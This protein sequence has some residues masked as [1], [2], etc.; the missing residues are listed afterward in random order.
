MNL[1]W[2]DESVS[3]PK[4][5]ALVP[6]VDSAKAPKAK[7]ATFSGTLPKIVE[8]P[9][10]EPFSFTPSGGV[11]I[12][13][14]RDVREKTTTIY[15]SAASDPSGAPALIPRTDIGKVAPPIAMSAGVAAAVGLD[16]GAGRIRVD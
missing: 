14:D 16:R 15:V 9:A 3:P 4:H 8:P 5:S 13:K 10:P 12:L 11:P 2:D 1:S 7:V 6:K